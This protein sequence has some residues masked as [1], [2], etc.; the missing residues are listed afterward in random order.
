MFSPA[1]KFVSHQQ[2]AYF[3]AKLKEFISKVLSLAIKHIDQ[4]R[5]LRYFT[6]F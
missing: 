5:G 1:R 3:Q 2:Q 4:N 6:L